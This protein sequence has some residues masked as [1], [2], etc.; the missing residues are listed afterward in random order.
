M[1]KKLKKKTQAKKLPIFSSQYLCT[2]NEMCQALGVGQH[3]IYARRRNNPDIYMLLD[4]AV[5]C[6]INKLDNDFL[7]KVKILRGSH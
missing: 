1:V 5:F 7:R 2:I 4:T 6:K 3:A